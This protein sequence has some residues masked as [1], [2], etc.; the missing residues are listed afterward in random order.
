[1]IIIFVLGLYTILLVLPSIATLFESFQHGHCLKTFSSGFTKI[2]PS[3]TLV[4]TLLHSLA[5]QTNVGT[6]FNHSCNLDNIAK[7]TSDMYR[8]L[9]L[10]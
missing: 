9:L 3:P 7:T 4:D 5:D 6:H 10:L 8:A 2:D 1:M